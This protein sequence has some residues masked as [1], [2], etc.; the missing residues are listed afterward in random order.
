MNV[1]DK[2]MSPWGIAEIQKISGSKC[3]IVYAN[4]EQKRICSLDLLRL[5][6][7]KAE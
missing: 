4:G 1:G 5:V 3:I 7:R 2:V 6:E